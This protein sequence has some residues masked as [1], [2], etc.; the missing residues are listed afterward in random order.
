NRKSLTWGWFQGGFTPSAITNGRA[1]CGTQHSNIGNSPSNDYSEHHE[2]FQYYA[3]TAN[4]NHNAP[5]SVDNVGVSDP[6]G[7]PLTSAVNHQYDISWFNQTLSNGNMPAVSFLKAPEYQDAHAGYSDPL[8]EQTFLVNEVNAIEQSPDWASTAIVIAY[9]DPDGRDDHQLGRIIR[10]SQDTADTLSGPGKCGSAA[11]PPAQNDRCGVGPRTPLLVISPWAKQNFVDNTF[12]EQASITRFI[13]D[14]WNLGR[15]GNE[16]A[17]SASGNL[18][19]AF[20]FN[21]SDH[22]APAIILNP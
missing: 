1:I 2:P 17:D 9:D 11:S 7:T 3:S 20:D 14:N 18:M 10:Q 19:N 8:D 6:T 4:P 5:S 21:S 12:T 16:S 13:E 15:I 22:R